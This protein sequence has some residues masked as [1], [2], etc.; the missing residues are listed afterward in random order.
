MRK[1]KGLGTSKKGETI[2]TMNPKFTLEFKSSAFSNT[3]RGS[4]GREF[5]NAVAKLTIWEA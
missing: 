2:G 1:A 4:V 5:N 3:P